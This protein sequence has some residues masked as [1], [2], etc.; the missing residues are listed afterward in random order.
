MWHPWDWGLSKTFGSVPV[1]AAGILHTRPRLHGRTL[2]PGC[3]VAHS[4]QAA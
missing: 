2:G 3:M 4:A 1:Q